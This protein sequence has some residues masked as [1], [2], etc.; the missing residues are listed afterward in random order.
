M[1]GKARRTMADIV[2]KLNRL[3]EVPAPG[4]EFEAWLAMGDGLGFLRDNQQDEDF[5]VYASAE[6]TYIYTV[7]VPEAAVAPPDIDDLMGWSCDPSSSWSVSVQ[8]SELRRVWIAPPMEHTDS[9]ALEQG[10]KLLFARHFLGLPEGKKRYYEASQKFTHLFDLH[11]MEE[12]QAYCRLNEHGDVE[13]VIRMA[14]C[15]A[16]GQREGATGITFNRDLLDEYLVLTESVLV[17][18]FD[19]TRHRPGQ[20]GGW[21]AG[22]D[23][24]I[25]SD[26]DLHY[27]LH[28][29]PGY[30][31]YARGIQLVRPLKP[32]DIVIRRFY[33]EKPEERQYASYIA[34]N[35]KNGVVR[36]VSCAPGATANRS[37]EDTS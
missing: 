29:E 30:A 22:Q 24:R 10:E 37:E 18:M 34:M 6:G 28:V 35:W 11:F 36:E 3:T 1:S 4:P 14:E 33:P 23:R 16:R 13:D 2:G 8:Y 17:R 12:R 9:R 32:K 19:F 20:F 27:L 26:G 7:T 21:S 15:E 31:S 25:H 5:L